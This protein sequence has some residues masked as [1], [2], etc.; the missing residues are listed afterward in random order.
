M[1]HRPFLRFC[2]TFLVPRSSPAVTDKPSTKSYIEVVSMSLSAEALLV[3]P[4]HAPLSRR[5]P[6]LLLGPRPKRSKIIC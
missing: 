4:L 2:S 3:H 6:F 5:V 1:Q